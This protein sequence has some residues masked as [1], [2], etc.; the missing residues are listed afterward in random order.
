MTPCS[1]ATR[2]PISPARRSS[3]ESKASGERRANGAGSQ[4]RPPCSRIRL[5]LE[6]SC[7]RAV[8]LRETPFTWTWHSERTVGQ[9]EVGPV[10]Q[11][12]G[13]NLRV[14]G[15]PGAIRRSM[16]EMVTSLDFASGRPTIYTGWPHPHE[17]S[18]LGSG[19]GLVRMYLPS[20]TERVLIG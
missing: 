1:P 17:T 7:V 3:S 6:R 19:S 13:L 8:K 14:A 16:S 2:P 9:Q 15:K 20:S 12:G 5:T 10:I 4:S 18:S 11:A